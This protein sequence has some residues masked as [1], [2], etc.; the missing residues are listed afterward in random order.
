MADLS[1]TALYTSQVWAWGQ[2]PCAELLASRDGKRVF[3]VTNAALGLMRRGTPLRFA[4]LHRH[5]MIDHL[6]GEWRPRRIVELAAGLSRRGAAVSADPAVH[7]VEVDLPDVVAHKRR[8]LE[9]SEAGRTVLARPNYAPGAT[10][11]SA[12]HNVPVG[13]FFNP[14]AFARPIVQAGRPIPSSNGSAIAGA[15]GTD[16]GH[17]GRNVLRGPRQTNMD[18]SIIKRFHIGEGKNIEFRAEFFN[19]FNQVNLAIP[20]SSFNAIPVGGFDAT[21]GQVINPGSFGQITS[22]SSN[23][24]LIQFAL[25]F[26]F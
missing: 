2:L 5:T 9:R 7:Y 6:V 20:I 19:L 23:Q 4:L 17:V 25:K 16:I 24:R 26:N 15:T 3:D 1:I 21:T 10:S 8:L 22:T 11:R 12:T 18:F 14:F 13:Y